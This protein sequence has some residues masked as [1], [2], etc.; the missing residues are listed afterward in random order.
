[1][2]EP[3][4]LIEPNWSYF[5]YEAAQDDQVNGPNVKKCPNCH[6]AV[7]GDGDL[8]PN[9]P[10][11]CPYCGASLT[12]VSPGPAHIVWDRADGTPVGTGGDAR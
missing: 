6:R 8:P 3:V 1:M 9:F 7:E 12:A 10:D 5:Q 2:T 11:E 4:N